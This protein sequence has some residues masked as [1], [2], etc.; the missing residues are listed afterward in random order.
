MAEDREIRREIWEGRIPVCISLATEDCNTLSAPDPYYL[1]VP[2]ISYF[3]LVLDK[4]RF[5]YLIFVYNYFYSE[6]KGN[7][8]N[9]RFLSKNKN[10]IK[11]I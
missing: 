11:Y 5:L 1:L 6:Y 9:V 7:L 10:Q 8:K 3:P 4:V 2:R